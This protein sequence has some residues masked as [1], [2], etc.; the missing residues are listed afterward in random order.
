MVK[1]F[2]VEV[3]RRHSDEPH[4]FYYPKVLDEDGEG[5]LDD[6]AEDIRVAACQEHFGPEAYE[7]ITVIFQEFEK[8]EWHARREKY[9]EE[10]AGDLS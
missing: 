10:H 3:V 9:F 7:D 6:V 4:V 1:Y 5:N 8:P 2:E